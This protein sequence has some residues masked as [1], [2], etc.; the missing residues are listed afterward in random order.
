MSQA[1]AQKQSVLPETV[2]G[3]QWADW[4]VQKALPLWSSAGYDRTRHLYH[5]RLTFDA[6][7][8]VM[9]DLR[10]M[11]QAR[12]IATFCRA[13]LDG[14]FDASE[15][16]LSCLSEV[17][18][19]YWRSDDQPGW[20]F[21]LGPDGRPSKTTRDLYAHAFILFAYAWAYRLSGDK[22][23]LKVVNATIAEI[24]SIFQAPSGGFLDAV[25]TPDKIR[26]QNPH[27]HLLEAYLVLF[28]VTADQFYMDKAQELITLAQDKLICQRSGMLLEFFGPD[29]TPCEAFGSNAV[30]PGH[31]FEWS[32]LL[33][34]AVRL[35]PA[36]AHNKD[37]R[38]SATRLFATGTQYGI[39]NDVVYDGITDN[40][41]VTHTSTR[42]WPQTEL[43]RLLACRNKP[44]A[45]NIS[46]AV[47]INLL[48]AITRNFFASYAPES[49]QGGWVD[50]RNGAGEATVDHM[51]A[52]SLYHIYGAI[53][54]FFRPSRL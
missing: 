48:N 51:P 14:V 12:Q 40:G 28:E 34:E 50:R 39:A 26:R 5:E 38:I 54:E 47:E 20:V 42:I 13:S 21:A 8:I 10:L 43:I 32:W 18:K 6:T 30:E 1:T 25:P 11:V 9:P 36:A 22:T 41:T 33:G 45:G 7:P 29:W 15:E 44:S 49:L 27:M 35:N 53:R 4:M 16:A 37:L 3:G 24:E 52:S 19:R 23:L 2:P 46:N 17:Q 31:L